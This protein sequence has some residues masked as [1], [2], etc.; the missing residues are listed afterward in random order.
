[1]I[2]AENC[3]FVTMDSGFAGRDSRSGMT[4]R[5]DRPVIAV[6]RH[7]DDKRRVAL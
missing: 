2:G 7:V 5:L 6:D 3:P 4:S 1:M